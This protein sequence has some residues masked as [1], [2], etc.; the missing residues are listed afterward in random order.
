MSQTTVA[1]HLHLHEIALPVPQEH[2]DLLAARFPAV[3]FL[4]AND[5]EALRAVLPRADA[6]YGWQFPRDLFAT[7]GRLRWIHMASAGVE[8]N[9]FPDLVRSRVVVTNSS[10][11][12]AACMAEHVIGTMIALARN[13]PE[14]MRLQA[15]RRWD[16]A[17]VITAGAGIREL[18]GSVVAVFGLGPVGATVA[19]YAAALGMRV[20]GVRRSMNRGTPPGVVEVAGPEDRDRI[21]AAADFVVLALP[22]TGE[23]R[24]IID[25]RALA[26]MKPGA[27]LI[28]V[29]RGSVVAEDALVAALSSQRIAGAALDVF[30]DEPL[31]ADSPLWGL[32]NVIAT[33]HVSGYTPGYLDKA[34]ELFMNNLDRFERGD[35]LENVVDKALGYCRPPAASD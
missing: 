18:R 21:L 32:P 28:N 24:R 25:A 22:A 5:A 34:L 10:G 11:L 13:F 17:A 19:R 35:A 8:A 14:A 27:F 31:P 20:L 3:R 29:A 26:A 15:E 4:A 16:R 7:A 6:F 23:T 12:H 30:A 9:L 2:L 33:P 1:L